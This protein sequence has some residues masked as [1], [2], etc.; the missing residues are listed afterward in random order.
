MKN[1]SCG[2]AYDSFPEGTRYHLGTLS[3]YYFECEI[4]HSTLYVPE[5]SL[6]AAAMLIESCEVCGQKECSETCDCAGCLESREADKDREH[7]EMSALG[8]K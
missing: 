2:A 3:G 7:D 8:Y 4:C 1:C 5:N 6:L